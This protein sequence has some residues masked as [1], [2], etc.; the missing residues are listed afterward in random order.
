MRHG[1]QKTAT[2]QTGFDST[3]LFT[4]SPLRRYDIR[5]PSCVYFSFLAHLKR[6]HVHR[7]NERVAVETR[8]F[9][10][11]L[12]DWH[13]KKNT[14]KTQE[15]PSLLLRSDHQQPGFFSVT[16]HRRSAQAQ[17]AGAP[18][19]RASPPALLQLCSPFGSNYCSRDLVHLRQL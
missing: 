5:W 15:V 3:Y 1:R 6:I 14:K 8:H 19:H 16:T 4:V 11:R 9:G 18:R 17:L 13:R 12:C 10:C 2:H 7:F